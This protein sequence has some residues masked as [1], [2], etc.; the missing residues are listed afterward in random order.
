MIDDRLS[1]GELI[2][3]DLEFARRQFVL[4]F[5]FIDA[6]DADVRFGLKAMRL[7]NGAIERADCFIGLSSLAIDAAFN[8]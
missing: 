8:G 7:A 6:S 2:D 5:V 1:I 4:A 3:G